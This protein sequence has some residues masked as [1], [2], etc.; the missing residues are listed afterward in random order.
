MKNVLIKDLC[1][2]CFYDNFAKFLVFFFEELETG[3]I[4]DFEKITLKNLSFKMKIDLDLECAKRYLDVLEDLD[5]IVIEN[6]NSNFLQITPQGIK[7]IEENQEYLMWLS[8]EIG[9][10]KKELIK[11]NEHNKSL[12][13]LLKKGQIIYDKEKSIF[14][15]STN[16]YK[17][18]KQD[19]LK[20][21]IIFLI[22][23]NLFFY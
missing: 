11:S 10:N 19:V 1:S 14:I 20:Y 18:E 4:D 5:K 6:K 13:Q 21:V 8:L 12:Q 7:K 22:V 16:E 3:K 17:N 2:D 15:R 23:K 9:K